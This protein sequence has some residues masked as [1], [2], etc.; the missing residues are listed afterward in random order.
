V[1]IKQFGMLVNNI[2]QSFLFLGRLII[3]QKP[4]L[5]L[6]PLLAAFRV[7]IFFWTFELL[8]I[9]LIF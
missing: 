3:T 6:S 7:I 8:L 4:S 5:I 9:T 1:K 2:K